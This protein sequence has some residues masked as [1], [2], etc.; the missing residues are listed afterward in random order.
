MRDKKDLPILLTAVKKRT[1][2]LLSGDADFL[3]IRLDL[4]TDKPIIMT[5]DDFQHAY[6]ELMAQCMDYYKDKEMGETCL[7]S[8]SALTR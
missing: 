4:P 5:E 8:H 3:H 6:P 2:I 1:D 7:F